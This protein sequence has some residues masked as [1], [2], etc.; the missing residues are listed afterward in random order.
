MLAM[1]SEEIS[2]IQPEAGVNKCLPCLSEYL[3]QR[4]R[5]PDSPRLSV[6]DAITWAPSWQMQ[7]IQGQLIFACVAVPVCHEHLE[8]KEKS[9][10][11][12][13]VEGGILLGG[14]G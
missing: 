12:R 8:T 2:F 14:Q 7:T 9:A 10:Q 4:K 5:M 3:E 1:D 13:A 6:N 11:E